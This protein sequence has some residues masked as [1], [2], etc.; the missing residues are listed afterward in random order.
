[1]KNNLVKLFIGLVLLASVSLLAAGCSANSVISSIAPSGGGTPL[2][3]KELNDIKGQLGL[4]VGGHYP[5]NY[6]LSRVYGTVTNGSK[7]DLKTITIGI[8]FGKQGQGTQVGQAEIKNL[9][10]GT[11]KSFDV[12]TTVN[13]ATQGE[14][15]LTLLGATK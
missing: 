11:K 1:M 10:A 7:Q 5:D 15:N 6:G 13:A 4:D 8:S 2:N 14:Y 12:A 9:P 3:T